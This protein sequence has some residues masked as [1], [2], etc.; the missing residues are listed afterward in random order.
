MLQ[1]HTRIL[2]VKSSLQDRPTLYN[3]HRFPKGL[4]I[5]GEESHNFVYH[6]LLSKR[7]SLNIRKQ[8]EGRNQ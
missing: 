8:R 1:R 4:P 5:N 7:Q 6:Q 2:M 3:R